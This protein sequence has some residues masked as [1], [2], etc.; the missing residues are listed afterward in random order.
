MQIPFNKAY[1]TGKEIEYI[2][3][4]IKNNRLAGDGKFT[5]KC[6]DWLEEKTNCKKALLTHSCT[7]ALEMAAIIAGIEPGDEVIMPSYTFVTTANAFVLRGGVPVFVDIKP[8]TLNLDENQLESAITEKT[9]AVLPV[10]YAGVSCEMDTIMRIAEKYN[11]LVIEDAAQGILCGY[12]GKPLG[13]IGHLAA[14]SFHETKNITSGEG[15]AL[16]VND[17]R[18]IK[19]AEIIREKGTNR[20]QFFRGEVNKY[21]WVDI[22]SSYLPSELNAA[23]LY[24]QMEMAEDI[25][26]KRLQLWNHYYEGLGALAANKKIELPYIGKD[27]I[28]NA[29]M[30]Y[31][32]TD[33]LAERAALIKDLKAKG[34]LSVFHYIPLH[35]S[36]AGKKYGRFTGEDRYTTRESERLLRLPLYRELGSSNVEYVVRA[37][38]E[39][40]ANQGGQ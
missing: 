25:T 15:G 13:S 4:A 39:F 34:V 18:F 40:Y 33:G 23:F 8:E 20:S 30:F 31:I 16:L 7:G 17:S 35:S 38:C 10:H 9:R 2:S 11:L 22:G 6:Q 3:E 19:R 27:C 5:K 29:H 37:I 26:I 36:Q 14:L 12:K 32:K 21:S 1:I 24:A 28:H